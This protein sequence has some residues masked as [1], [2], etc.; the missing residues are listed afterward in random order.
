MEEFREYVNCR[1]CGSDDYEV[2]YEWPSNYYDHSKYETASWDGRQQVPLRIC[3]C[4]KCRL[5]YSNPSFKEE[6]L[7]LVYPED[8]VPS[9][10][11]VTSED[12]FFDLLNF[13][14]YED[15]YEIVKQYLRSQSNATILDIG[16][17]YGGLPYYFREQNYN[18]YGLELNERSVELAN[19]FGLDYIYKG[20]LSDLRNYF[21]GLLPKDLDCV[22]MDDVL[23]HLVNPLED[24]QAIS[25]CQEEGDILVM[26]QMN[27]N[28]LGHKLFGKEWYYLQPAAHMSYFTPKTAKELLK[29]CGYDN[30]KVHQKDNLLNTILTV[31][32]NLKQ[33]IFGKREW[34]VENGKTMYLQER[35]K[36]YDDMFTII[37]VRQ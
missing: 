17:R 35:S 2:V 26:R 29:K 6:Y 34:I 13:K 33:L 5:V 7:D 19:K 4:N 27:W 1:F 28:S 8:I 15:I 21:G 24:I 9:L 12:D 32:R 23:E 30:F 36:M 37:A 22:V 3:K 10:D 11:N 18:S 25:N 31:A 14:K 20:T 16:T